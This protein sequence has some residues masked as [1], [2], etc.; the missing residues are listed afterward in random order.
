[1]VGVFPYNPGPMCSRVFS[2]DV[3]VFCIGISASQMMMLEEAGV[4]QQIQHGKPLTR[5]VEPCC[6]R[7][8]LWEVTTETLTIL[9]TSMNRRFEPELL[10]SQKCCAYQMVWNVQSNNLS[11]QFYQ[12]SSIPHLPFC[13]WSD[14]VPRY[15]GNTAH[16]PKSTK[17]KLKNLLANAAPFV[18]FTSSIFFV[19][20]RTRKVCDSIPRIHT[21]H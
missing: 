13:A 19:M 15:N 12:T 10:S 1:M 21:Q 8:I 16:H 11:T 3:V 18:K 7:L 4:E 6:K 5:H 9:Q 14:P 17:P 2:H 20:A